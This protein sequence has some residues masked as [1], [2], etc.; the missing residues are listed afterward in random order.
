M[1]E[2][3]Y[4]KMVYLE[5][6]NK[7]SWKDIIGKGYRSCCYTTDYQKNGRIILFGFDKNDNPQVY[8]CPWKSYVKYAVKYKTEEKDI[9]NRYIATKYFKSKYERDNYVK[10]SSGLQVVECQRPE[11]EFLHYMFDYDVLDPNFNK[12]NLRIFALDI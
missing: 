7:T 11:Q 9:Y 8:S 12:Q 10:S 2:E 5:E 3:L 1:S 6:T 4:N